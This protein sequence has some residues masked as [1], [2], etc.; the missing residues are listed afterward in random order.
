MNTFML[1]VCLPHGSTQPAE[2]H[3]QLA[4]RLARF[5]RTRRVLP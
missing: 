5:D 3:T 2:L 1:L 4:A